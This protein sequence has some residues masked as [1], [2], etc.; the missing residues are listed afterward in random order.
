[1]GEPVQLVV[2]EDRVESM[3]GLSPEALAE[4][5]RRAVPFRVLVNQ[6]IAVEEGEPLWFFEGCLSVEGY[7]ALVPRAR[8]VRMRALDEQAEPVVSAHARLEWCARTG[9]E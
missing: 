6:E 3:R 7:A 5:E 2:L 4:R 1:V 9:P 8:A